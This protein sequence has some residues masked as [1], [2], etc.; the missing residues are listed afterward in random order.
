[1]F[2][3]VC[4]LS[5]RSSAASA[6]VRNRGRFFLANLVLQHFGYRGFDGSTGAITDRCY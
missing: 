3:S 4:F 6:V 1:M 2:S 5:L